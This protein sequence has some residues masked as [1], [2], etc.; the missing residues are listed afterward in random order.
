MAV[1]GFTSSLKASVFLASISWGTKALRK[2]N[3]A[4]NWDGIP[5]RRQSFFVEAAVQ[6]A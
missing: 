4:N 3:S 6:L 2:V 1:M 5:L